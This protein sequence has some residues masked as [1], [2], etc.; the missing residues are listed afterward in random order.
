MRTGSFVRTVLPAFGDWLIIF[1]FSTSVLYLFFTSPKR[2]VNP[3]CF[4]S[5]SRRFIAFSFVRPVRAG[6]SRRAVSSDRLPSDTA[7]VI[8]V[9][10]GIR[11]SG[12][13]LCSITLP[14]STTSL[15]SS[16]TPFSP[17][18][19]F[20]PVTSCC[21]SSMVSPASSGIMTSSCPP[22]IIT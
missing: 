5:F 7:S 15:Y 20:C 6:T 8:S 4:F 14:F 21:A 12:A 16:R 10:T 9:C 18:I 22:L 17:S 1:P 11:S 2:N 13:T 3:A 19:R